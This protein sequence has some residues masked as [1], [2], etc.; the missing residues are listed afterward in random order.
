MSLSDEL[1]TG[2]GEL[3]FAGVDERLW[4][5]HDLKQQPPQ[6]G[7]YVDRLADEIEI[8]RL[9][10]MKVLVC[11]HDRPLHGHLTT[12]FVRLAQEGLCGLQWWVS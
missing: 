1:W 3:H 8:E 6:P 7:D 5:D 2:E 12:K 11:D 9:V 10:E 4:S